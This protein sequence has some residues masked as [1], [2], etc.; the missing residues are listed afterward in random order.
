MGSADMALLV[1]IAFVAIGAFGLS[2]IALTLR[3][4]A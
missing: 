2:V 4:E 1:N 3:G